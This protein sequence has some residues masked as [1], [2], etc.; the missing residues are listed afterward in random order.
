MFLV[1]TTVCEV[2]LNSSSK[3]SNSSNSLQ[4]RTHQER[5]HGGCNS[6]QCRS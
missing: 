2:M 6:E 3:I 5:L 4:A 1:F